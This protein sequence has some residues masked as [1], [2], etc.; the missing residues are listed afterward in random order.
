MKAKRTAKKSTTDTPTDLALADIEVNREVQQRVDHHK[1][2]VEDYTRAIKD[3]VVLPPLIVYR[4]DGDLI[5]ADGFHRHTAY[6][7]AEQTV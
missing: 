4:I 7:N 2:A 1:E 3:G 6:H 5:L